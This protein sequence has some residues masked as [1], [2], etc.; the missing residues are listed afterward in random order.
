LLDRAARGISHHSFMDL[1][2]LVPEGALMVFNDSRVRKARLYARQEG[3]D[4]ER[5]FLLTARVDGKIWEFMT[6]GASKLKDSARFEFPE[7]RFARLEAGEDGERRLVFDADLDEDYFERSGHVPL[8][9]YIKR[10]DA[11]EDAERYQTTYARESGSSAAPT[12]GLHFTPQ[13]MDS[14]R[15]R[16]I[17]TEFICLHVGPGTFLPVRTE[18]IEDHLMHEEV[19]EVSPETA[20][21][22]NAARAAKRPIIAVGTTSMRS[23]E[24]AWD[25]RISELRAGQARTRLFITPGYVFKAVE[26]LFTN[27]HTPES[28]LLIL[29]CA[30]AGK[31]FLL[32]AYQEAVASSYRFFSYGDAMLIL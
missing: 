24:S 1:P 28:T 23:L 25:E 9:P 32:R 27:F 16:G 2:K 8:P 5:E 26:G 4:G 30:F 21:A 15:K 14:L 18:E 12:A 13:I 20:A 11:E 7:A 22:V 19:Y 6:Q 3:K 31:D 10:P 17:Q 29:A